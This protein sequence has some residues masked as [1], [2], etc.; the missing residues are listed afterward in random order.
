MAKLPDGPVV[1]D[2]F[3]RDTVTNGRA[4]SSTAAVSSRYHTPARRHAA[5]QYD[6]LDTQPTFCWSLDVPQCRPRRGRRNCLS[7][8]SGP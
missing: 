3:R 2:R 7:G 8:P 6:W 5:D 4:R 1:R